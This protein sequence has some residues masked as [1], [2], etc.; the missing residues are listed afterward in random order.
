MAMGV[1]VVLSSVL[2]VE[3]QGECSRN[4]PCPNPG[5]C[6]SKYGYCGEGDPYCGDGCQGGPCSG[7]GGG[8]GGG[9]GRLGDILTRSLYEQFFPGHLPF[10]SY[11]A[12]IEAAKAFPQFGTT[13]DTNTRKREIAAFAAHATHETSGL[14]KIN[15]DTN[16][17]NHYCDHKPQFPC[18]GQYFGRGP[19]QLSWNYNYG[20]CGN[21][22]GVDLLGNPGLVATNNVISFKSSLWFWNKYGDNV[23]PHIHDVITGSWRPNSADRAANRVPGF[24][25][26]ID[27]INGDLECN[28]ES[29]KAN[30]RVQY[31]R[32][33]CSRLGVAPGSN[34]DCKRMRP[35]YGVNA[36]AESY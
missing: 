13:G 10:Y 30:S 4:Q 5:Y 26:T 29:P 27:I 23:I 9:G 33:F 24:G 6:C 14:T 16:D 19:L 12:L 8:G 11:D 22:I 32:N 35:F 36:A 17:P 20:T 1:V 2:V 15:E 31:F 28:Q 25:V 7:G 18:R 21:D 34:L 3:A